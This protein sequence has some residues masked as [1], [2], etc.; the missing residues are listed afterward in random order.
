MFLLAPINITLSQPF[1][2]SV[3]EPKQYLEVAQLL[4]GT[5]CNSQET[6]H[7]S[8]AVHRASVSRAYYAAFLSADKKSSANGRGTNV[9]HDTLIASFSDSRNPTKM[10]IGNSLK[11]LKASRIKSDYHI[12]ECITRKECGRSLGLSEKIITLLE[13]IPS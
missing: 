4:Y 3:F 1:N 13:T 7:L 10:V 9:S 8:E 5:D 2:I 6:R 11:T 12:N